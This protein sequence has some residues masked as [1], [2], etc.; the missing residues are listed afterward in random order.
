V[1][2]AIKVANSS[3]M[4]WH[5]FGSTMAMRTEVVTGDKVGAEVADW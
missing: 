2:L 1:L 5:Q 4:V 3:S